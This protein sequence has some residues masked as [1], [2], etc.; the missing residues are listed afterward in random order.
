MPGLR[1]E[2]GEKEE[3]WGAGTIPQGLSILCKGSPLPW[4]EGLGVRDVYP[5]ASMFDTEG[6]PHPG[7]LP[8][9]RGRIVNGGGKVDHPDGLTT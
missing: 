4:G 7:P 5:L 8:G 6:P 3:R 2:N 1:Q 9:G